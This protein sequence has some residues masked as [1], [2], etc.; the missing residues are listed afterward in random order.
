MTSLS[1]ERQ[2][3]I[4]NTLIDDDAGGVFIRIF[5]DRM[6][7]R[8]LS[9]FF[10]ACGGGVLIFAIAQLMVTP[11]TFLQSIPI[12]SAGLLF[13]LL[14]WV[15]RY[16]PRTRCTTIHATAAGLE[17]AANGFAPRVVER[18][19]IQRVFTRDAPLSRRVF[20]GLRFVDGGEMVLGAGDS[21]EI[22]TMAKA[23]HRVLNVSNPEPV[24]RS[25]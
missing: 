18:A 15:L 23:I 16:T 8:A 11:L 20:L 24:A 12:L 13:F 10:A 1:Y 17:Y 4:G 9:W 14:A 7:G 21:K 2:P 25:Q 19:K 22:D 6:L 3:P 5:P